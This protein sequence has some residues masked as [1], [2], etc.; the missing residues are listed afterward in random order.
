[1]K[2][3]VKVTDV[4]LAMADGRMG[5]RV[6]VQLRSTGRELIAQINGPRT[7]VVKIQ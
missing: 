4:G 6:R 7:A 1:M 5:E 2:G 3:S